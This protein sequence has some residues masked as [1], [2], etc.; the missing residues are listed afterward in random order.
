MA[1]V[2]YFCRVLLEP[3]DQPGTPASKVRL[4]SQ[5]HQ[6]LGANQVP[7]EHQEWM[8]KR[9]QKEPKENE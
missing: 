6:D 3:K 8:E 1:M 9:G 7:R 5:A 4:E 2:Y